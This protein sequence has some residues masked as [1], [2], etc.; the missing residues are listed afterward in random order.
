MTIYNSQLKNYKLNT[1]IRFRE[2]SH[3]LIF[4]PS[5]D[6]WVARGGSDPS[7]LLGEYNPHDLRVSLVW[8]S[9]CFKDEE[10]RKQWDPKKTDFDVEEILTVREAAQCCWQEV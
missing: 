4:Q 5:L 7:T 6:R 2:T 3:M 8:R 1:R 9:L 10:E